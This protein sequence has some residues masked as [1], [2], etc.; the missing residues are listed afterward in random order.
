VWN[1]LRHG[2]PLEAD[3]YHRR[4]LRLA[5]RFGQPVPHNARVLRLLE[6]AYRLGHGP[7]SLTARALLGS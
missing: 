1:A 3:G 5:A 7:E 2:G 6:E 4:L